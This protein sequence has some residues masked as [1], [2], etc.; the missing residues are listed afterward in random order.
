MKVAMNNNKNIFLKSELSNQEQD[1]ET[2][3][4]HIIPVPL[5]KTVSYGKGTSKGPRSIIY[6]S[7]ELERY[8]GKSEPCS[9]GIFTHPMLDCNMPLK[10]IMSNIGNLTKEVSSKNKIPITLGGEHSVTYGAVNG[11]FEGLN[12]KQKTK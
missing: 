4:F 3:K 6:A 1:Q 8:T 9:E 11:I 2:S 12:L 5:E 10:D 7:N